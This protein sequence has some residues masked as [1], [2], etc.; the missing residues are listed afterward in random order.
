MMPVAM[1]HESSLE[2]S[3]L[4]DLYVQYAPE[5]IR[6]AFL[7][8]GDRSRFGANRFIPRVLPVRRVVARTRLQSKR[9][10][11]SRDHRVGAERLPACHVG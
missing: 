6:L 3:R 10:S 5:A 7:L 1:A 2:R 8:T 9:Q 4:G 11:I